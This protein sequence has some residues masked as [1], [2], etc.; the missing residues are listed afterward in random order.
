M[1]VVTSVYVRVIIV[2]MMDVKMIVLREKM[3][4]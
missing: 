2:T 1:I 4:G 3:S